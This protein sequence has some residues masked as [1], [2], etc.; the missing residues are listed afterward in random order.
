MAIGVT[1]IPIRAINLIIKLIG[2]SLI[3]V[4]GGLGCSATTEENID[5]DM[6]VFIT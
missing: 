3:M 6:V 4:L 2:L 1:M 5:V